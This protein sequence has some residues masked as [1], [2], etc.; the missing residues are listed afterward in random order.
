MKNMND[1]KIKSILEKLPFK[2]AVW[3]APII[4]FF[5][6]LEEAVFGFYTFFGGNATLIQFIIANSIIMSVYLILLVLFTLRPNRLNA[7]FVLTL[8]AA[9]QFFNTFYHLLWT[10][11]FSRY[12]PG[13]VT[14]LL[15]YVPFFGLI[16]WIAYRDEY[17]TKRSAVLIILL[18]ATLMTLFEIRGLQ[19]IIL[20]VSPTVVVVANIIDYFKT[21]T[22]S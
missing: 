11:V 7:F 15:I 6:F 22:K 21:K 16:M 2:K 14:G 13:V 19:L 12:C 20:I 9:A 4:Y 5:H 3:L 8:I 1:S 17:I 10:I 18:G